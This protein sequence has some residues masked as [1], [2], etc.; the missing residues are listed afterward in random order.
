MA[1]QGYEAQSSGGGVYSLGAVSKFTARRSMQMFSHNT[2]RKFSARRARK[3]VLDELGFGNSRIS[4]IVL[5]LSYFH[6]VTPAPLQ[7]LGS[8][9]GPQYHFHKKPPLSVNLSG[10]TP[11]MSPTWGSLGSGCTV[12][13]IPP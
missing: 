9:I 1:G 3:R 10:G 12:N 8:S 2:D 7:T 13:Y 6:R 4:P 11:N 5:R